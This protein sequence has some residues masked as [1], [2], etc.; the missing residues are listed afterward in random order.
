MWAHIARETKA[1]VSWYHVE[2]LNGTYGGQGGVGLKQKTGR[3]VC[4]LA[5]RKARNPTIKGRE[6]FRNNSKPTRHGLTVCGSMGLPNDMP[7]NQNLIYVAH[8]H[9]KAVD[10]IMTK[11]DGCDSREINQLA[12]GSNYRCSSC[13]CCVKTSFLAI[14][15][16]FFS[17]L[18]TDRLYNKIV[19][20]KL[21]DENNNKSILYIQRKRQ[22]A[23]QLISSAIICLFLFFY[24]LV[25][26]AYNRRPAFPN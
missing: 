23:T 1:F 19:T 12:L 3:A 17:S 14:Y 11:N 4:I 13:S 5:R 25:S 20:T 21:N 9:H 15:S 26:T 6:F 16:V 18:W 10:E 22:A 2:I 8:M 7:I 24:S